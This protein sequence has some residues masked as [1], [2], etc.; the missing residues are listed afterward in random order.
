LRLSRGTSPVS[1]S[2]EDM[3]AR[4]VRTSARAV[5]LDISTLKPGDYLVQLEV[6]VAGQYV[7]RADRRITVVP[8]R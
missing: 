4:G 3:S 2:I 8:D 6:D 1:V 7:I 5:Q